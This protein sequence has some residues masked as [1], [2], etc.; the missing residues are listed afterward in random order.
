MATASLEERMAALE[1]EVAEL[2]KRLEREPSRAVLPWWKRI[3]GV[4]REDPEFEEAV[5]LR[6]EYRESLRPPD[7][8]TSD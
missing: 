4:Y 5:R 7:D 3:V 1:A 6:R 8:A 2:R